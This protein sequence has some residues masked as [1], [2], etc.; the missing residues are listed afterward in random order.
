MRIKGLRSIRGRVRLALAAMVAALRT[1]GDSPVFKKF[2][3]RRRVCL[4]EGPA[5]AEERGGAPSVLVIVIT[6]AT[7]AALTA[8][9]HDLQAVVA[10]TVVLLGAGVSAARRLR[11]R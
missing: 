7:A 10:F 4:P 6:F 5:T 3:H 8:A 2:Q 1:R 11:S 9:G